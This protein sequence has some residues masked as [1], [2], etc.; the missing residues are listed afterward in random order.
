V[1]IAVRKSSGLR[2]CEDVPGFHCYGADFCYTAVE[3]GH[4]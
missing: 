1:L 2:F 3:K 4:A